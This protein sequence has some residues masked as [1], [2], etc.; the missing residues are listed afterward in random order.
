[1]NNINIISAGKSIV[2]SKSFARAILVTGFVIMTVLGAYVRIP[3]PFTPVPITLQTFFV[4]LAGAVL[5]RKAGFFSQLSYVGLGGLGMPIFQ[6][7][8]AG[9]LHLMGPTGGYLIGFMVASFVTGALIDKKRNSLKFPYVIFA[10]SIGLLAI[11]ICGIT[12]L[13]LAYKADFIKAVSLGFIPFIPGAAVKLI[14]A[15]WIYS[16]IRFR[17]DAFV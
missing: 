11:Y 17:T 12:W 4:L 5:G 10:M 8:G 9:I 6:G 14:A 15:S 3:L 2:A 16:K 1:M 7:Y 13:M